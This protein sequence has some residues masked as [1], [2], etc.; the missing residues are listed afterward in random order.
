[1]FVGTIRRL[2]GGRCCRW[3]ALHVVFSPW[4]PRLSRPS[5][6][7]PAPLLG[8]PCCSLLRPRLRCPSSCRPAPPLCPRPPPLVPPSVFCTRP[9]R[10]RPCPCWPW[11]C[12]AVGP[13]CRPC[14][15]FWPGCCRRL[16]LV[17]VMLVAPLPGLVSCPR[18]GPVL[19][20]P[21]IPCLGVGA[22]PGLGARLAASCSRFASLESTPAFASP[23][24]CPGFAI[25]CPWPCRARRSLPRRQCHVLPLRR[26]SLRW[27]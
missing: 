17:G 5:S 8:P 27:T 25:P 22:L 2:A 10:C 13:P 12:P 24:P 18:P 21:A 4:R 15:R 16:V 7:R 11:R 14:C 9:W 3:R 26:S 19:V 6:R 20:A 1:M 23:S